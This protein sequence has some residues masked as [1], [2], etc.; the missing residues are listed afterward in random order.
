MAQQHGERGA[1]ICE[2]VRLGTSRAVTHRVDACNA[3]LRAPHLDGLR[4]IA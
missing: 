4:P 1:G 3:D 2:G